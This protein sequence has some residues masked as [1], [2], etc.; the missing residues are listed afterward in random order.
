LSAYLHS[1]PNLFREIVETHRDRAALKWSDGV[2]VTFDELD[3]LS[4]RAAQFLQRQRVRKGDRVCIRLDKCTLAY[5]LILACLKTG[6]PYFVVDPSNPPAR[7]NHI[8]DKCMPKLIFSAR[9]QPLDL[10]DHR[11][12]VVDREN[13]FAALD[14]AGEGAFEPETD[15]IG[16]DPAYIMFTSGSTGFPKGAVMSHANLLNFIQWAKWE[17]S[18]TPEDVF[19]NVNPLY[20]DN[21]VFDFYASIMNGAAL[22][23]F[24]AA[25]MRDPYQVLRRIDELRCTIYFS[26][27]SLLIYFQT[28]KMIT[29]A[30]F[31]HV[32]TVIFGGEGYPKSKLK[33]LF[34]CFHARAE[35]VN[36][37]GPT[38][39]TCICSAYRVTE[40]DFENLDGYPPLG[41]P[42]PSFSFA[43]LNEQNKAAAADEV[44][45]LYLGGPCVGLGYF[46]DPELTKNAFRQ[47]PLN[48]Y[49]HERIYR[50][51]DLVRLSTADGKIH[52][53]GRNDSQ[54]K[55]QGYRIEL[56]EIEHAL[57]RVSG[58]DEAVA[59]H[60]TRD[61]ISIIVAVVASCD[62]L[63]ADTVRK[64]VSSVVPA[65]MV[66]G[67]VEVMDRLPKNDNG[68]ID[69][70]LL[71]S[72]YS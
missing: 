29:P 45:E 37:Y 7:V 55:H 3:R 33:E 67:R 61:G 13:E 31:A 57:C 64:E 36:V 58:V 2:I 11:V 59:L 60:A 72:R 52:F 43:I 9:E 68:K 30:A 17:F 4:D 69:R 41:G 42:I 65:Y 6:A 21:S 14:E 71:K 62:G 5:S 70:T 35:L 66:P 51:G 1:V 25:T 39:C 8:L 23:P 44:G 12:I 47:N 34:D 49:Y 20:F 48:S 10:F 40:D 22:V 19:T 26:V 15:I 24:D 16:T 38:E 28:L 46:N 32:R 56:G 50:T 54:I 27:P 63:T 53:A 18:I